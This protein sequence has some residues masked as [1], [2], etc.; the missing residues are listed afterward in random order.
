[1]YFLSVIVDSRIFSCFRASGF[2]LSRRSSPFQ[3]DKVV[4]MS[5]PFFTRACSMASC[6]SLVFKSPPH[7]VRI[8]IAA[9]TNSSSPPCGLFVHKKHKAKET[10]S[11][12]NAQQLRQNVFFVVSL[13]FPQRQQ[14]GHHGKRRELLAIRQLHPNVLIEIVIR[15]IHA[16]SNEIKEGRHH[17]RVLRCVAL[18]EQNDGLQV[19]AF[20]EESPIPHLRGCETIGEELKTS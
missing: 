10:H 9:T 1:M 13:S 3:T 20:D 5:T 19:V 18:A 6:L 17:E 14:R 8:G 11:L 12:L 16:D 2:V 7:S 15:C 4:Y